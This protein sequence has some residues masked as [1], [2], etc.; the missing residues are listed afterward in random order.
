MQSK[1]LMVS[2]C[3]GLVAAGSPVAV[4]AQESAPP[5][6]RVAP[7]IRWPTRA[8]FGTT[9][10]C[11]FS[12][13]ADYDTVTCWGSG[14]VDLVMLEGPKCVFCSNAGRYYYSSYQVYLRRGGCFAGVARRA[15]LRVA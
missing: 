5:S 14:A 8:P 1:L 2:L 15:F 6:I 10:R 13:V 3:A 9:I 7:V 12:Y 4:P 11:P